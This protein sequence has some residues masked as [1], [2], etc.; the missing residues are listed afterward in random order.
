MRMKIMRALILGLALIAAGPA[1]AAEPPKV[2]WSKVPAKVVKLFY[3]GQASYQWTRSADH[4]KADKK[5][6]AG[7]ACL[8]CHEGEEADIG[9]KIAAGKRHETLKLDGKAGTV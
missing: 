5:V 1:F 9:D 3:P 8:E 7:T 4:K 2:D 6:Q